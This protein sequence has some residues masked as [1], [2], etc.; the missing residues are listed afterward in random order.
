MKSSVRNV[1]A[2]KPATIKGLVLL[3]HQ[4]PPISETQLIHLADLSRIKIS[5]S[6]NESLKLC[7][8]IGSML[9]MLKM[10]DG[11][12]NDSLTSSQQHLP[13]EVV[14]RMQEYR[15]DVVCEGGI[16]NVLL[17]YPNERESSYYSVP[18]MVH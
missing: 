7:R 6:S 15:E 4:A 8:E 2:I 14:S 13:S 16:S 17:Q 11:Y 18:K 1:H 9:S 3:L 10:I 5:P 12:S